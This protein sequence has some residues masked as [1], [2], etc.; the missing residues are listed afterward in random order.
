MG[1]YTKLPSQVKV[2][3]TPY[4]AHVPEERLA[5][6]K[7]LIKVSPIGPVSYENQQEDR[8]WG[9]PRQWLADAKEHWATK[10]DW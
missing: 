2:K 1:D 5:Q 8:S 3:P 6:M 7:E 9:M 4:K 10:F